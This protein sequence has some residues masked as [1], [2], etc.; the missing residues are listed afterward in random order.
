[1]KPVVLLVED[2]APVASLL[3]DYLRND[4]FEPVWQQTGGDALA[5]LAHNEAALVLLDLG[6]PDIPGMEICRRVRQASGL[7]IIMLTGRDT[8]MD[9]VLGLELGA[10]DYVCKPFSLREVAARVRTVL[11]RGQ[12]A[13]AVRDTLTLDDDSGRAQIG[14]RDVQLT[15]VEYQLLRLMAVRPGRL[16]SRAQLID[17]MYA[18]GRV[19][20]ERTVDSH[21]RKI[22][23]KLAAV[24]PGQEFIQ[25]AYGAGYRFEAAPRRAGALAPAGQSC[26][27]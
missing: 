9:R 6:L 22:R 2:E 14:G 5:W 17:G 18:D 12:P 4:G 27:V 26:L 1:M 23:Q 20:T 16:F 19:V 21:I 8:E 25:S 7:P 10:D 24:A 15:V 13:P 3:F 11:R